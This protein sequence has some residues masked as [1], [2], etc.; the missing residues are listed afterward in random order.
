MRPRVCVAL[1]LGLSS[2]LGMSADSAA[3]TL[4]SDVPRLRLQLRGPVS[5]SADTELD[6]HTLPVGSYNF[7]THGPQTQ[8]TRG[9][10]HR[11]AEGV[12]LSSWANA[13]SLLLPPGLIETVHHD[14]RGWI[15]LG[16]GAVSTGLWW[17]LNSTA[18]DAEEA[19]L[20]AV[21]R[22]RNSSDTLEIQAAGL[23][24][25]D[26][27]QQFNDDNR[28]RKIWLA[29]IGGLWLGSALDSWL[30]TPSATMSI[31]SG[32][33]VQLSLP[34][35]SGG[36]SAL[37]S[38]LIP[39]AGQR[40]VG[41]DSR[42]NFFLSSFLANTAASLVAQDAFLTAR[43]EVST[44]ERR[45]AAATT[46]EGQARWRSELES[47]KKDEDD[48]SLVRWVLLGTSAYV[49][50]WNVIDAYRVGRPDNATGPRFSFTPTRDGARFALSWNLD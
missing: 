16:S 5:V 45:F 31:Q 15:Y 6:L 23:D 25:L 43:R 37:R 50:L 27:R 8:T 47:S 24:E 46:P 7:F 12:E 9:R 32:G 21:D 10:L 2:C 22:R 40:A 26:A 34:A 38:A 49:Y 41:R 44:A 39:G 14:P 42:A 36:S 19:I 48:L 13:T 11:T 30:L 20:A 4:R 18:D 33:E 35:R 17:W 1:A 29:Y 3:Q 28:L